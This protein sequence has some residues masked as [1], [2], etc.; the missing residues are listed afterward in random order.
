M[1]AQWA[2]GYTTMSRGELDDAT[3]VLTDALEFGTR[4]E[5]TE[6]ILPPLWGLA[7]VALQAGDP[8]R[9]LDLCRDALAR[10]VAV[11][12]RVLLTPFVVTGVRAAQGAG[13]P[14]EAASWLEA[15]VA[16]LD[17]IRDVAGAALDHGRGLVA[18]ADGST[19]IAR[20]ALEAAVD[21]WDGHGRVWEATG[22]RLDLAHC[23]IRTNRFAE[24]VD[25][26]TAA[27]TGAE[28]LASPALADRAETLLRM[29]R[30]HA[31]DDEPWRPLTAR[32]FEVARLI[33]E[34]MTNAEIADS[35]GIAPK[36]ASSHVEH[37]LAKLGASRRAEIATW[38]SQVQ[39]RLDAGLAR[40]PVGRHGDPRVAVFLRAAASSGAPDAPKRRRACRRRDV[41]AAWA[42]RRRGPGSPRSCAAW[43][44]AR[45]TTRPGMDRRRPRSHRAGPASA[46]P[47]PTGPLIAAAIATATIDA[48]S[49]RPRRPLDRASG[50][51]CRVHVLPPRRPVPA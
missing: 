37:I 25:M 16:Q 47:P 48:A 19:G 9:A 44:R 43:R 21:G 32:E 20:V 14:A 3:A 34:G 26:A 4:S 31:S 49:R 18:L 40:R 23:L 11:D 6:L 51:V 8:K 45:W 30:G 42:I 39:T 17:S 2:L 15:C 1:T 33:G 29:A 36:T 41:A 27:R 10:A 13:R 12:E 24:A 22:A 5:Q 50:C 38:A 7:E 46:G 35:L 28:R